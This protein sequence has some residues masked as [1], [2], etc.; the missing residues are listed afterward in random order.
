PSKTSWRAPTASATRQGDG[1]PRSPG[2][3]KRRVSW[4]GP[5]A[6]AMPTSS[7][8]S[9]EMC[10]RGLRRWPTNWGCRWTTPPPATPTAVRSAVPRPAT[11]RP[12]RPSGGEAAALDEGLGD[13]DGVE[14]GAFAQVVAADEQGQSTLGPG[15]AADT[16]DVAEVGAGGE[17]RR[18]DVGEGDAGSGGE[19][20]AGLVRGEGPLELDVQ[21]ERVAGVD[22][23]P[24]AR[25]RDRQVGELEDLAALVAPLLLLVGLLVDEVAGLRQD[26]EG[27]GAGKDV[28]LGELHRRTVECQ[29][30]GL[31]AHLCHLL[32]QLVDA[33][34]PRARYGLV[35]AHHD[36]P[37]TSGV[38]KG[39]ERRHP[40]HGRAVGVGND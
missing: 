22:G 27:D 33:L 6:K 25:A 17:Q 31:L 36:A 20:L 23:H 1:P 12:D 26:V 3:R 13:L 40:D 35:G 32:G 15:V 7:S 5:C 10:W 16:A 8:T 21:R 29:R 38:V 14:G 28:R 4:R 2:W 30:R 11:V 24:H 37:Q 9:W 19:D 39:L 34:Q 18:R